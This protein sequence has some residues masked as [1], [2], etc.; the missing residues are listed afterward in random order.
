MGK[1]RNLSA[2]THVITTGRHSLSRCIIIP[3]S[4]HIRL[5]GI[6]LHVLPALQ[7]QAQLPALD[8]HIHER[9]VRVHV[10]RHVALLHVSRELQRPLQLQPDRATI[11]SGCT[12]RLYFY[13]LMLVA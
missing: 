9:G 5:D 7:R 12:L 8:A 2:A 1:A 3:G 11:T 13:V 10:A 4:H 6:A